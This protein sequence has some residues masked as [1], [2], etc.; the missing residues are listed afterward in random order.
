[1]RRA[2]KIR[3]K[4]TDEQQSLLAH[5]FGC[6]RWVWNDALALK[7]KEYRE[8][9]V[10]ISISNLMKRLPAL[11]QE[12]PW[13]KD[14]DSQVLQQTLRNMQRAY[15]NFFAKRARFPQFKRKNNRQSIQYPQ[16]V[17]I[18]GSLIY[19]PKVGWVEAVIHREIVGTIKTVTVS[20]TPTGKFFASILT[21]DGISEIEPRTDFSAEQI[22]AVDVGL[23]HFYADDLGKK[24]CNPRHLRSALNQLR[25]A[26]RALSRKK[27]GSS[28][29]T[30]AKLRVARCHE[31]I[32]AARN[33]FQHK[34]TFHLAS[35]SQAVG[36]EDLNVSG[37]LKNRRLARAIADAGW[38]S[39]T[40]KLAYKLERSGGRLVK[41]DRFYPS[42]KSCSSCG[43]KLDEMPLNIRTWT[44][45][46]CLIEH[47]RDINAALN[48]KAATI[49]ELKA[50]GCTVSACGG[51]RKT[52][53]IPLL[54]L[55]Q[56]LLEATPE[57]SSYATA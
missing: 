7:S 42:S 27:K 41:I 43:H 44:C 4:P 16:R 55:K 8:N 38:R 54:P 35:E 34:L 13:L 49:I 39:F 40:A 23:T 10:C 56:E 3:L 20:K 21:E 32:A 6:V 9:K 25:K 24:V 31:R 1:M 47:D 33:D 18:D 37:M 36:V 12:H 52:G 30:K 50:G 51:L 15:E 19:L 26:Q 28:N 11:K 17:K 2:T 22:R 29:R 46:E 57:A 48:I 14:A 45:P 53:E 5:Q